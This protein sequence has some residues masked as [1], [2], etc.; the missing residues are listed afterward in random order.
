[1]ASAK[2]KARSWNNRTMRLFVITK[3]N[4]KRQRELRQQE[5]TKQRQE[6]R[7]VSQRQE[8]ITTALQEAGNAD[9]FCVPWS[10]EL[11]WARSPYFLPLAGIFDQFVGPEWR[12]TVVSN[13]NDS[14]LPGWFFERVV[15]A[16]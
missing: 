6:R 5:R 14:G 1:M 4:E 7:L 3:R 2:G 15:R 9:S 16:A 8:Y 13:M 11:S 12:V 10:P